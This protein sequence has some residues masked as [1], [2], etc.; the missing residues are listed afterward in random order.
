MRGVRR[1]GQSRGA[2]LRLRAG[3]DRNSGTK[4]APRSLIVSGLQGDVCVALTPPHRYDEVGQRTGCRMRAVQPEALIFEVLFRGPKI[5]TSR[6]IARTVRTK[7]ATSRLNSGTINRA[8]L[9]A[10]CWWSRAQIGNPTSR[11]DVETATVIAT[12]S[13]NVLALSSRTERG[14]FGGL[15]EMCNT[16]QLRWG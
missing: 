11:T 2:C 13:T 12:V 15:C 8:R 5:D 14:G 10:A 1:G 7:H 16:R 6:R 4:M 3:V 9:H